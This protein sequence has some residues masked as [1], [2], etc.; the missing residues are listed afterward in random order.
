MRT[1]SKQELDEIFA[2]DGAV[3]AT[4]PN[5]TVT[6]PQINTTSYGFPYGGSNW[7]GP[8]YNEY[9]TACY[10]GAGTYFALYW[11][12]AP[13]LPDIRC[14]VNAAADPGMTV[15]GT[16]SLTFVNDYAFVNQ[17][18]SSI[19]HQVTSATPAG[20]EPLTGQTS[21]AHNA[22]MLYAGGVVSNG[23]TNAYEDPATGTSQQPWITPMTAVEHQILVLAHE[24][25][26]G[27]G[28]VS[29]A[30]AEGYAVNALKR[31][32]AEGAKCP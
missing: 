16:A 8:V 19:L 26:H 17:T 9:G 20:Y 28:V 3:S 10:A 31:F 13:N 6:A 14:E 32:R 21:A 1:L 27:R 5:V 7:A 30:R 2:G 24:A 25:A 22:I 29:E 15:P 18:D 23:S 4:L 12:Q 11:P